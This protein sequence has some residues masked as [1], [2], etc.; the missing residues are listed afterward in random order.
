MSAP[1]QASRLGRNR[2]FLWFWTG[3]G[4]S[5]LG[6][7]F[8]QLAIPVL[9]VSL[10]GATE[11]QVGVLGAAETAAFLVVGLPAGAWIDRM[12][13][14]RVMIVA[15]LVRALALAAV[16][17]LFFAG[18]LQIWHLYV[19]GAVVGM[20]TVFFDVSYQSYIPVLLPGGQVG[21]A[22]SRLEA[23]SQVARIG[24][25]GLAG[26]LL[27]VVSAPV[28]LLADGVS[29]LVSAF[30]LWRVRDAETLPDPAERESLPKEIAEGLRFVL[31]HPILRRIT[32]TTATSNLFSTLAV[33][34]ESILILRIL[35]FSPAV[36]GI[37]FGIGSVG[38][39]LGA[40]ATPWITKRIGEGT[41]V[42]LSALAMGA[43]I[44]TVPLA[45]MFPSAALPLLIGG[46][47]LESFLVL[48][49]NITQVTMRQR[50]TPAR[51]L[52]RMNASIR[53]VVWGVMP[54]ASIVSGILGTVIG[55]LP[56][57]WIGAAGTVFACS[58]VLFSP[59]TRMKVL[60][61]DQVA[62]DRIS[63]E[64]VAADALDDPAGLPDRD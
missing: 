38:G 45:G 2:S 32:A 62:D 52:G 12:L 24:G 9:A 53:F 29:Y 19:V 49:Y 15:D 7:Q 41:A 44:L 26:A 27:T 48:V 46:A 61:T 22:N 63:V 11:F 33:T 21:P 3:E 58:F 10:L 56:T 5:Q 60:P 50:L 57:I 35:G 1:A 30:C 31:G 54:I 43:A 17:I 37:I 16:P 64:D 20:A 23:T 51:L 25:P 59:I 8:S 34:L 40:L 28:L 13:K 47:F 42:S 4:I 39:L 36:L 55:V 6:T 14:R 18:A